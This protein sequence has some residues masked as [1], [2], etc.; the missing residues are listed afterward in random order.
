MTEEARSLWMQRE[1]MKDIRLVNEVNEMELQQ[2][3]GNASSKKFQD[4]MQT[5]RDVLASIEIVNEH[6]YSLSP[7]QSEIMLLLVQCILKQIFTTEE[8]IRHLPYLLEYF[9]ISELF[10]DLIVQMRRRGGKTVVASC[11]VGIFIVCMPRGNTNVFSSSKRVSMEMKAVVV[12]V[13]EKL[14][15]HGERFRGAKIIRSNEEQLIVQSIHGTLNILN[16]FPCNEK[17][18]ATVP[19]PPPLGE[20]PLS[21]P[22][23]LSSHHPPTPPPSLPPTLSHFLCERARERFRCRWGG[24]KKMLSVA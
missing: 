21:V 1:G 20:E 5:L 18:G 11:F 22:H 17:I 8:L 14:I 9:G 23:S 19:L 12:N 6:V 2:G 24:S 10:E 3:G 15:K 4:G 13:V 16:V 7:Q